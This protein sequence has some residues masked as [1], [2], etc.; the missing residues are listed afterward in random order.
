MPTLRTWQ[1]C[2]REWRRRGLGHPVG[3]TL[4]VSGRPTGCAPLTLQALAFRDA[5]APTSRR[6]E[7]GWRYN[8]SSH[9]RSRARQRTLAQLS[10]AG[11]GRHGTFSCSISAHSQRA[12]QS[13]YSH[14]AQHHIPPSKQLSHHH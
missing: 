3:V 8:R 10:G 4:A 11:V 1:H 2:R 9:L 13:R 12:R 5:S 7:P 14:S 6:F